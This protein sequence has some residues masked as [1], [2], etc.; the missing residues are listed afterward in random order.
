ME[1]RPGISERERAALRA[2]PLTREQRRQV[3]EALTDPGTVTLFRGR[4]TRGKG[5]S[6]TTTTAKPSLPLIAAQMRLQAI[7]AKAK[8]LTLSTAKARVE[9]LRRRGAK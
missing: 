9:Q 1:K 3:A 5:W 6:T 4:T 2:K 7:R 8:P